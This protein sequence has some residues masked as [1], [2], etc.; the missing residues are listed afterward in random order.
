MFGSLQGDIE[1]WVA[2]ADI[3]LALSKL[4]LEEWSGIT[5]YEENVLHLRGTNKDIKL[6]ESTNGHLE[7]NLAKNIKNNEKG[8]VEDLEKCRGKLFSHL[9]E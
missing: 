5:N 9:K 4:K 3:L 6:E 1:I 7:V 8:V 2:D